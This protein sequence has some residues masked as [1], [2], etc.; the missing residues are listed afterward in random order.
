MKMKVNRV[1][2]PLQ[3]LLL[4]PSPPPHS[5]SHPDKHCLENNT[6]LPNV[7]K[8]PTQV[9]G[10]LKQNLGVFYCVLPHH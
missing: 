6:S 1:W 2:L 3:T 10:A 7:I 9:F 4:P 8:N 5:C